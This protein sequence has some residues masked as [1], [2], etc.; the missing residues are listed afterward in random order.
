MGAKPG[1]EL[2]DKQLPPQEDEEGEEEESGVTPGAG[3]F[4]VSD[5]PYFSYRCGFR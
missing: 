1:E 5:M 3:K 4:L 2:E